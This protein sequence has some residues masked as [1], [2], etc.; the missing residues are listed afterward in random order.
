MA[1]NIIPRICCLQ[2]ARRFVRAATVDLLHSMDYGE[3]RMWHLPYRD[4][5]R[6]TR[7][8]TGFR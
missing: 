5:A 1:L 2:E 3:S 4:T 6:S 8:D 7:T